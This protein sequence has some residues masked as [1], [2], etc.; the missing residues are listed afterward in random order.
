MLIGDWNA[1]GRASKPNVERTSISTILILRRC[2]DPANRPEPAGERTPEPRPPK[3]LETVARRLYLPSGFLN[4]VSDLL[5]D[6]KQV[7]FQGPPGTGKTYVARVLAQTLAE[8]D[9]RVTLVQLHPSYAYEDFVQGF[10]P[11]LNA[12]Q[13]WV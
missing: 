7:I 2:G 12:G 9:E 3:D 4:S 5:E 1:S 10:R 13:N 8:S 11:T 6:K